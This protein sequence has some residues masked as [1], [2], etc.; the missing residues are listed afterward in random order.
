MTRFST[1]SRTPEEVDIYKS[2]YTIVSDSREDSPS[3]IIRCVLLLDRRSRGLCGGLRIFSMVLSYN[4]DK[5][6]RGVWS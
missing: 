3:G 5:F 4:V 1:P 2:R 6:R